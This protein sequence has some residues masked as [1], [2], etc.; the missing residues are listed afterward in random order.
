[1]TKR[2][3][4]ALS[5]VVTLTVVGVATVP[6]SLAANTSKA[7]GTIAGPYSSGSGLAPVAPAV[8]AHLAF[9]VTYSGLK[10]YLAP[11]VYAACS[12]NGV[13]VYGELKSAWT[14]V[15]D[16]PHFGYDSTWSVTGGP[17]DCTVSLVAYAGLDHG[18]TVAWLDSV[19][20]TASG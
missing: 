4:A 16:F 15:A 1:M 5:V 10:G 20:F 3:A 17:A 12:Q 18:G 13:Q 11:Y 2:L 7:S 6:M 8:G 19:S 9:D 14:G